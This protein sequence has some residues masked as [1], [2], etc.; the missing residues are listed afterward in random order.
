MSEQGQVITYALDAI[1][2]KNEQYNP[3]SEKTTPYVPDPGSMSRSSN[4]YWKPL[5]QNTN[6]QSG[7]DTT[8]GNPLELSV[9]GALGE[10]E[11]VHNGLRADEMRDERLIKRNISAAMDVL[12]EGVEMDAFSKIATHGA[13]CLPTAAAAGKDNVFSVMNE[14]DSRFFDSKM[15]Q[16]AG[17][18]AFLNSSVMN[19]GA[20]E[21]VK[22]SANMSM[23]INDQ[24]YKKGLTSMQ[25]GGIEEVYKGNNLAT[26]GAASTDTIT[27][28]TTT[29]LKP[30]AKS[31]N[32]NANGAYDNVDH[33]FGDIDVTGSTLTDV[34]IGHKFS[35]PGRKACSLTSGNI[36][37]EYDQTF[38]IVAKPDANTITVSPRPIAASDPS[39]TAEQKVYANIATQITA[40]D[41]LNFLNVSSEKSSI[42]MLDKS[43]VLA[44]S[45]IPFA[46]EMFQGLDAEP[47]EVAGIKGLIGFESSLGKLTG[48]YRMAIWY[49]WQVE[50]PEACGILPFGQT[51]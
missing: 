6:R 21:L 47:F 28:I 45:P 15:Y 36:P 40:G 9:S 13:F 29:S 20:L 7:W 27:V 33:R 37:L 8:A 17:A 32:V 18:T 26:V 12:L 16:G 38:T 30:L 34:K 11:S 31:E 4:Q 44:S 5:Q 1:V 43:I 51:A 22:G 2:E 49:D 46:H 35:V 10:P 39:L 50:R 24:A 48:E 42:V 23:A 19:A 41:E 3:L 14:A 25:V